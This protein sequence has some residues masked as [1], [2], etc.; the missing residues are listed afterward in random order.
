MPARAL[1]RRRWASTSPRST[2]SRWPRPTRYQRLKTPPILSA[3]WRTFT[4]THDTEG[5]ALVS[6][7]LSNLSLA[8]GTLTHS[9]GTVVNNGDTLTA[10]ELNTLIYT[11]AAD[12]TGSPLATFDFTVNDAGAGVV[13]AQ[14]G[15][16]V[17]AVNDIPVA[18]ANTVS[19]AEDT[20]YT[21][22]VADFTFTDTEGDALVS[23]RLSNLSLASGT[24]THSGGTVVNN[25]DTLTAAEGADGRNVPRST[26][27]GGG[28]Q[29][30]PTLNTTPAADATGSPLATFDFTVND[31]GA[32]VVAAQMGVNVTAV[33]DIPVATANTVST[34]EDTA[35]TFSA[36]GLYLYRHR[37]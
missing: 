25:G 27:S 13:A 11:P 31:A 21:F 9:G 20:A 34:A 30:G 22:S 18:T 36:G 10:A 8:S 12:A 19:T 37:R 17:T 29:H 26:I 1:S 6:A 23:A 24:L 4:F 7:R 5:D 33:N 32:G 16:N 2:I 28:S 15:V 14:M 35:Y 3:L